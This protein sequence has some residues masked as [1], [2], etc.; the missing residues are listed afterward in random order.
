[1]TEILAYF[2]HLRVKLENQVVRIDKLNGIAYFILFLKL[3]II[4]SASTSITSPFF[5][6]S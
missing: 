2:L 6:I 5:A 3:I 4:V 1:M